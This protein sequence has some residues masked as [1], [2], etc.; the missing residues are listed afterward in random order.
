MN[1]K[2]WELDP[3]MRSEPMWINCRT[4]ETFAGPIDTDQK[5]LDALP[6]LEPILWIYRLKREQGID[7][8]HAFM[9]TA[10]IYIDAPKEMRP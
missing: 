8:L 10:Q 5:A 6:Q 1:D 2:D 4:D 9:E 3:L 7:I